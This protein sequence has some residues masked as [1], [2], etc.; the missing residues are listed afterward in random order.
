MKKNHNNK[1]VVQPLRGLDAF[2]APQQKRYFQ[3]VLIDR[4]L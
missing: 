2:S 3:G 1:F 4:N